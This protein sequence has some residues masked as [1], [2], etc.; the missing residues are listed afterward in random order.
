MSDDHDK[1]ELDELDLSDVDADNVGPPD[2][3][4]AP[5]VPAWHT[6]VFMMLVPGLLFAIILAIFALLL[7]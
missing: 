3:D 6:P 1:D 7:R 2:P 4:E 5:H